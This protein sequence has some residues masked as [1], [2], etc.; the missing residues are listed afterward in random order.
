[1]AVTPTWRLVMFDLDGTLV[2][3]APEI[4][5]AL[6]DTLT[7]F[8]LPPVAQAQVDVWI[9]QGMRALLVQA[10]AS[11]WG[12]TPAAV[13]ADARLPALRDAFSAHL[14]ARSGTRSRPYPH[15]REVLATLRAG[16]AHVA[17]VTN[18]EG[19]Q[20]AALLKVHALDGCFDTIICGDTLPTKKP[21]PAGIRHCLDHFGVTA[22]DALFVG[23]SSIDVAAARNAR[24]PV[25]A[26]PWGYNMGQP[27]ADS[28][29]DRV[30][31]SLWDLVA[32]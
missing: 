12:T 24:V 21:D 14:L 17:L 13:Q 5:D 10:L 15:A 31:G 25:W 11:L 9:G 30:M 1:M 27:I 7:A 18:K 26:L 28:R 23:D 4:F 2:E 29:P 16:G 20:A 8:N 19:Q 22:A 6:T 3:T 32:H